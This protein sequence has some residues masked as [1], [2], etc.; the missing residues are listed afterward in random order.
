MRRRL[1]IPLL[2]AALAVAGCPTGDDDT[3]EPPTPEPPPTPVYVTVGTHLERLGW[4]PESFPEDCEQLAEFQTKLL[5]YADLFE[6]YGVKWNLQ[7]A[8]ALPSRIGQ[9]EG[10]GEAVLYDG[11]NVLAYL[12]HH[13]DVMIDAHLHDEGVELNYADVA[14]IL[15]KTGIPFDTLTVVGGYETNNQEQFDQLSAG[16]TGSLFPDSTWTPDL[17]TFAAVPGHLP[18]TE[19]FSSGLWRPSGLDYDPGV[20]APGELYYLDDPDARMIA[21]GSGHLHGCATG[22]EQARFWYASDYIEALADAIADDTAPP[23]QPYTATI[24]T[25]HFHMYEIDEYL[26][27]FEAQLQALQPLVEQGRVEYVHFHDLPRI[28][29]Q[30][31]GNE[32]STYRFE[33]ISEDVYTCDEQGNRIER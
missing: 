30:E 1:A 7:T 12:Q 27:L 25:M 14:V 22:Y 11:E 28:W 16:L 6:Q 29:D 8:Y 32:P 23:D 15:G 4:Y 10:A 9:C 3:V 21:V 24:A 18:G 19:E 26:P 31:Y 5:A 2:L 17:F 20:D 13:R 33:E